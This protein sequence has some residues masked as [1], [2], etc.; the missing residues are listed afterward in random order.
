MTAQTIGAALT[1]VPYA[2]P[3]AQS[4]HLNGKV[5][6]AFVNLEPSLQGC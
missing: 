6:V 2:D 5:V 1:G 3:S 4:V